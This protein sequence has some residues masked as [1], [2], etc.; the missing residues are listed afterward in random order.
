MP[1]YNGMRFL[2]QSLPPL[3]ANREPEL[4]EVDDANGLLFGVTVTKTKEQ[5][6]DAEREAAALPGDDTAGQL[7]INNSTW[8]IDYMRVRVAG[9]TR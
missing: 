2:E 5:I 1:V 7:K 4:L 3:L 8:Q 9:E 6:A